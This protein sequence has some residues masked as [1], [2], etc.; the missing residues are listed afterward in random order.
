MKLAQKNASG[1][2]STQLLKIMNPVI[3]AIMA[4]LVIQLLIG[5]MFPFVYFNDSIDK[6]VGLDQNSPKAH[7]F[8]GFRRIGLFIFIPT[9]L[10]SSALLYKNKFPV[11]LIILTNVIF[12]FLTFAP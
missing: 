7:F 3:S 5:I 6:Y 9:G 12:A 10:I 1:S 11:I 8:R 4:A 2:F